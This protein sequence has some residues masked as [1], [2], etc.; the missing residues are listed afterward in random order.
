ME[1]RKLSSDSDRQQFKALA[2]YCFND[3]DGFWTPRI[4]P[5]M[6]NSWGAGIFEEDKLLAG[7]LSVRHPVLF[8]GK[9][10][11][12]SGISGVVSTPESRNR[13]LVRQVISWLLQKDREDGCSVSALYPFL[14]RFYQKFGFGTAGAGQTYTFKPESLRFRTAPSGKLE[15]W[16]G[17]RLPLFFSGHSE[18]DG[19]KDKQSAPSESVLTPLMEVYNSWVSRYQLGIPMTQESAAHMV[20]TLARDK[21]Y[22]YV[23]RT[24]S[25]DVSGW[26][27]FSFENYGRFM[28]RLHVHRCAWSN[29]EALSALLWFLWSHRDQVI[30][31]SWRKG[32]SPDISQWVEEP[33]ID[34]KVIQDWMFRPLHVQKLLEQR[35]KRSGFDGRVKISLQDPIFSDQ[36]ATYVIDGGTVAQEPANQEYEVDFPLFSSLLIGSKRADDAA[37]AEKIPPATG[38][39]SADRLFARNEDIFLT[40]FF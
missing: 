9:V 15:P 12:L 13:G 3:H 2:A 31:I 27:L 11:E 4:F 34:I 36:C 8:D 22:L 14:F 28:N 29:P 38:I 6:G 33:R 18:Q 21:R 7:T 19:G 16:P 1:I 39:Q 40:E 24:A 23:Y 30:E 32:G 5:Q 10:Y 17:N 20:K 37:L 35:V 25:G 26:I